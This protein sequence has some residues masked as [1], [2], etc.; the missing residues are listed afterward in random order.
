MTIRKAIRRRKCN[1]QS[2]RDWSPPAVG[3]AIVSWFERWVQYWPHDYPNNI[4]RL[5]CLENIEIFNCT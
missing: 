2:K 4:K 1:F 3:G 5:I